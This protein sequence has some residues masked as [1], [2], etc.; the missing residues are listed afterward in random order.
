MPGQQSHDQPA[1]YA[2]SGKHSRKRDG[3]DDQ[4][5]TFVR[6]QLPHRLGAV[7]KVQ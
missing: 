6:L 3:W 1:D 2:A 4:A 5:S 7:L